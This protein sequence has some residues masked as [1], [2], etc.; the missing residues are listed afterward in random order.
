MN[1]GVRTGAF[2][3]AAERPEKLSYYTRKAVETSAENAARENR[4]PLDACPYR[5]DFAP[6][7]FQHWMAVFL[8]AG[9]RVS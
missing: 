6:A 9:G 5:M 4:T 2:V 7:E 1:D 3:V 8:V